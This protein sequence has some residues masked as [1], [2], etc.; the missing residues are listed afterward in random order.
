LSLR[1]C[2]VCGTPMVVN[3]TNFLNHEILE[4]AK[5][6]IKIQQRK[7]VRECKGKGGEISK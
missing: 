1:Q 4:R 6:S 7:S 5:G 3:L 2:P